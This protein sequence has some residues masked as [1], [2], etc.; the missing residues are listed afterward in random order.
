MSTRPMSPRR[1]W[2]LATVVV[3]L[4]FLA[5]ALAG[6][7]F[8]RFHRGRNHER[9]RGERHIGEMMKHRYGL[10]DDQARRVEAIVQKRRPRVDS[11]MATVEPQVRAVFD[12]T[13]REIR[14]LLTPGQREKFDRD[15]A[16]RRHRWPGPLPP[17]PRP[18][19]GR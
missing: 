19:P 1:V 12:S 5:G 13:N 10:S 3:L 15:Q 18:P 16:R 2:L 14:A 7:A 8:D 17:G 9:G 6:A 4:A 11:L